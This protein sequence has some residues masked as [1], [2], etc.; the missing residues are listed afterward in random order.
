MRAEAMRLLD[1]EADLRRAIMH[2]A[3]EPHFQPILRLQDGANVGYEA[4]VR[5]NHE[6]R[7]LLS[8]AEFI[9]VGE[10]SSLI[11]QVDWLMYAHVV[12]SMSACPQH[13]IS[14]NVSPRHFL[15]D[16]FADRLLRMLDEAGQ[17]PG[18][19]RIEITEVAL[20]EDAARALRVLRILR[21]HGVAAL[22]DDFGTGFSA[23]SYL[24]RFPIQGL[25]IDRSFVAELQGESSTETL[26]LVRAILAMAITLGIDT[27]AEGIETE[28]QRRIL[29]EQGCQFGQ[30]YLLGRPRPMVR[31]GQGGRRLGPG[32]H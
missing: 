19:L 32:I 10:D 28:D 12:A 15:S 3:F 30:G 17:D 6:H 31:G 27:I 1:L 21:D 2:D 7:G 9:G 5:W 13:Y 26:A 24:H 22:L 16:N 20:I 29:L 8:P 18:R 4:L 14:I 11:E 23:L 25:K